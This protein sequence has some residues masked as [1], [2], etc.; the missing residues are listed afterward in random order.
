[1]GAH[2]VQFYEDDTFLIKGLADYVGAALSAG[3]RAIAAATG[4]HLALLERLLTARGLLG[5]GGEA[6]KGHYTRIDVNK[7]LALF[8]DDGR[9]DEKRFRDTLGNVIIE[10]VQDRERRLFICGE[11]GALLLA[12]AGGAHCPQE[13]AHDAAVCIECYINILLDQFD[14]NALCVYPLSA[15]PSASDTGLFREMCAL[16]AEVLPAE[17]YDPADQRGSL[18]RTVAW[19]QQRQKN[20]EAE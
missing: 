4:E 3:N 19:L 6:I 10:A 8:M 17:S 20:G 12:R 1:M 11:M 16:H 13:T 2:T 7:A 15:F 9:F 5:V 18:Q 14:F